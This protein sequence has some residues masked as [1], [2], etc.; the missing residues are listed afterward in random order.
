MRAE[1]FAALSRFGV[2]TQRHRWEMTK[3]DYFG[4]WR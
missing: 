1:Y 4:V 3:Y 2:T